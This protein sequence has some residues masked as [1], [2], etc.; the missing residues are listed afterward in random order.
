MSV[1]DPGEMTQEEQMQLLTADMTDCGEYVVHDH[2]D[3]ESGSLDV[4]NSDCAE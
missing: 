1:A 4:T 2:A 3:L